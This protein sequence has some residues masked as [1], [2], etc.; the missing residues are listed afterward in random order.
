M[1]KDLARSSIIKFL[2]R[3]PALWEA[4]LRLKGGIAISDSKLETRPRYGYGQPPHWKLH[5]IINKNREDYQKCLKDFLYLEKY[6]W[7]IP[8]EE[9]SSPTLP[10]W[11]NSYFPA[12]D[13]IALYSFICINNP[14][15]YLEVGSGNSTKF[16][17]KAIIDH[18]LKTKIIS[19][20]PSPTAQIDNICDR[21]I[22]ARL[23]DVNLDI[24]EELDCNDILFFDSSHRCFMNSDVT[25]AF[26]DIFPNLKSN[27]LMHFHDIFLPYDYPPGWEDRYYSEQ[28][29]LAA[30]LLADSNKF[31]ISLPNYFILNDDELKKIISPLT[32]RL[33]LK[34]TP[35]SGGSFWVRKN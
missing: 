19:I 9:P 2:Q 25:V 35:E 34:L 23:E 20:D 5:D 12:L 13:A 7:Q 24:F 11:N 6:F 21:V 33:G 4:S 29:I 10:Y 18:K 26:L 27:I 15:T 3:Y 8:Q 32:E 28:Y 1:I 17:R 22:R 30:Y 16:C 14:N 31:T